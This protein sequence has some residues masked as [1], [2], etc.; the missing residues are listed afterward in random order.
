MGKPARTGSALVIVTV[1]DVN[2]EKPQFF[3][4]RYYFNISEN[5]P[6][7]SK[8]GLVSAEDR[9]SALHSGFSYSFFP[10][11]T[12][13]NKFSI[14]PQSGMITTTQ[15]L[16]REDRD[17]YHI[18]VVARDNKL[19]ALSDTTSVTIYVTDQ[20]DNSPVF[21]FPTVANNTVHISS[22]TSID[23]AITRVVAHDIDYGAN[24]RLTYFIDDDDDDDDD[25]RMFSIDPNGGVVAVKVSLVNFDYRVFVLSII[26][27]D[28]GHLSRSTRAELFVVVNRTYPYGTA[29]TSDDDNGRSSLSSTGSPL[30][31]VVVAVAFGCFVVVM[32]IVVALIVVDR[33][34]QRRQKSNKMSNCHALLSLAETK[35]MN[36]KLQNGS[37]SDAFVH[38]LA[39][40]ASAAD[41]REVSIYGNYFLHE[42]LWKIV[43]VYMVDKLGCL[44]GV[45]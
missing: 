7:G 32:S 19:P 1:D 37:S 39:S 17:A 35:P 41:N 38:K 29:A 20:N 2:D 45:V 10:G 30:I 8:V 22:Y 4:S 43:G 31:Y 9:D 3:R 5:E 16:D 28:N 33:K 24:S 6:T 23:Q 26:A 13:A 25:G 36:S 44:C 18:G 42:F 12:D 14:D 15:P 21:D 40:T 34:K 11:K 27:N